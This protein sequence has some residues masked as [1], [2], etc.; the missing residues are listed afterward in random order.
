M[1]RR[2]RLCRNRIRGDHGRMK[3]SPRDHLRCASVRGPGPA[4][5]RDPSRIS[6]APAMPSWAATRAQCRMTTPPI[7]AC[8]SC[9][10][11]RRCGAKKIGSGRQG[12]RGLPWRGGR[13]H[14]RRRRALSCLRQGSSAVPSISSSASISAAPIIS[15]PRRWR[16]RA[17]ICSRWKPLSRSNRAV[18]RSRPA[19]IRSS[20]RLSRRAASSS[21]SARASSISPAPI[22]MTTTGTG[23]SRGRRSPSASDRLPDLPAGVADAGFAGAAPAQL[24]LRHP[25]PGL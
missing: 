17:T 10:T 13:E 25:R 11:A 23:S 9:S 24:H 14:E 12:L 2:Q 18:S 7:P 16:T 21:C 3:L 4:R 19:T 1:D 5:R 8:C 15:R 6:A 20:R 22:A